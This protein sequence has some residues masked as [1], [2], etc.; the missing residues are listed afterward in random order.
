MMQPFMS[1]RRHETECNTQAS[2]DYSGDQM[3]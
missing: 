2:I 3:N 1:N